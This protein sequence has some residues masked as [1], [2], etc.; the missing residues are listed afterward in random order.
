MAEQGGSCSHERTDRQV[1]L[2]A[3]DHPRHTDRNDRDV[4]HLTKNIKQVSRID[5]SRIEYAKDSHK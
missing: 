2:T 1:D 3:D 4:R 5:E